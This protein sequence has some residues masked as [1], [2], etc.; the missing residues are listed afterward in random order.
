MVAALRK[1]NNIGV[2]FDMRKILIP[3]I[4]LIAVAFGGPAMGKGKGIIVTTTTALADF[5]R[6]IGG[7]RVEVYSLARGY[8]DPHF[9]EPKPSHIIKLKRAELFLV[10][11]FLL[12]SGY[13]PT[14]EHG[15]GNPEVMQGGS[16][17]IDCSSGIRPIEIPD[18]PDRSM[19]DVHPSGNPH[20]L[21]DPHNSIIVVNTIARAMKSRFPADADQFE[22]NRKKYVHR[23]QEC[24]AGWDARLSRLKGLKVVDYHRNWS[25]LIRRYGMQLVG[26]VEPRPGI[27][28]SPAHVARLIDKMKGLN[29]RYIL[30]ASYFETSVP[31]SVA[32]A[33]GGKVIVLPE[34]PGATKEATGYIE[35]MNTIAE[36]LAGATQ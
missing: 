23:L 4:L 6:H 24:I 36:R 19:G 35:W 21:A 9:V 17:Y 28:P 3:A 10:Q 26:T 16:R 31:E 11:G 7:D 14:L 29:C 8:E 18:R 27:T 22:E 2:R 1:G 13:A 5:A 20:Y 25:Y 30:A 34:M 12:E 32:R 33:V 15:T